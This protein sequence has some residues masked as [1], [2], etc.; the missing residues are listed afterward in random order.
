MIFEET[1]LVLDNESEVAVMSSINGLHSKKAMII[2]ARRLQ[3]I[4]ECDLVYR[5]E[6]G[7]IIRER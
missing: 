3:T 7:K 1:T 6:N 4:K 2:L 5:V